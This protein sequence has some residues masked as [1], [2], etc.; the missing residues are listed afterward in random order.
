MVV[1]ERLHVDF[2]K[3]ILIFLNYINSNQEIIF[4]IQNIAIRNETT[5]CSK[6]LKHSNESSIIKVCCFK[7]N[8][9]RST[10]K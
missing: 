9:L 5:I 10:Q 6:P 7:L 3:F 8:H 2:R 1:L 4:Y